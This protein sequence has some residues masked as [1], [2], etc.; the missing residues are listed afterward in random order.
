VSDIVIER[1]QDVRIEISAEAG[2]E[3]ANVRFDGATV[4][5]AR[6]WGGATEALSVTASLPVADAAR[7]LGKRLRARVVVEVLP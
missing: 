1:E 3:T 6:G 2:G 7:L 4:I 5:H